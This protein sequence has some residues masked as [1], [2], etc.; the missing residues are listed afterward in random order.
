MTGSR[1]LELI[2]NMVKTGMPGGLELATV[3]SVSPLSI[4]IDAMDTDIPAAFLYISESLIEHE[5]DIEAVDLEVEATT[6]IVDSHTHEVLALDITESPVTINT[7]LQ[8]G[9]RVAVMPLGSG[10]KYYLIDKAVSA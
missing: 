4:R 7:R 2:Q 10:Q 8:V 1:L 6:T 9:D 5:V 3:K